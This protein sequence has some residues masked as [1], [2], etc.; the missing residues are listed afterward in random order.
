MIR[1][2]SSLL[3]LSIFLHPV[4][5]AT[6]YVVDFE[7]Q[8]PAIGF[9][10]ADWLA[11]GLSDVGWVTASERAT[12]DTGVSHGGRQSLKVA[13]PKSAVGP[14][15]GGY[16]AKVLLEPREQYYL[17][18]WLRFSEN[19]SWGNAEH[20]G[21]LP[22]LAQ[23]KTCSGGDI[24]DGSNGFTARYMWRRNGAAV[25]YLYHMDKPHQWGEDFPLAVEGDGLLVFKPGEWVNLVQRVKINTGEQANGELQIWANGVEALSLSGLRFVTGGYKIDTFYFSTFHG[26]NTPEWGPLNDSYLWIDDIK[27]SSNP[28][29]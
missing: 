12:L 1:A 23:G 27:I 13:F 8:T 17:S 6:E 22:G 25:L 18:Y 9:E 28:L 4:A 2:L 10:R 5:I 21:K 24:C 26:G 7:R 29:H 19:F 11:Y 3:L 20:G 16:Q 15:R 14:A